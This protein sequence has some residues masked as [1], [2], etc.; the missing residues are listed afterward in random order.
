MREVIKKVPEL[1]K[2]RVE[3]AALGFERMARR[4]NELLQKT[5]LSPEEEREIDLIFNNAVIV[6]EILQGKIP[7]ELSKDKK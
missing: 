3:K 2:E 4:L 1:T 6:D 5:K 7:E